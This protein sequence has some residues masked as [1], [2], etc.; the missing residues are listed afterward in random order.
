MIARAE[1]AAFGVVT[2]LQA[3]AALWGG[4]VPTASGAGPEAA[5]LAAQSLIA[6]GARGLL[7]FGVCAAL[8]PD[9]RPGDLVLATTVLG[10][11]QRRF[12]AEAAWAAK[13]ARAIAPVTLAPI[14]GCDRPI[15][16]TAEK[17]EL[18]AATHA[19]AVDMESHAVAEAALRA[20]VQFAALRAVIDA[21]GM[22]VPGAALAGFKADGAISVAG[23]LWG[24]VKSPN[25]LPDLIR[26]ARCANR[27]RTS[28]SRVASLGPAVLGPD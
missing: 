2:G 24:L 1:A 21:A 11:D 8:S 9:L 6:R 28:L 20:G 4:S 25:D 27:A 3:E 15:A 19:A 16:T 23:V 12:A 10:P 17:A 26:L 22:A 13:L 5:L 7:S 14:L 18:F